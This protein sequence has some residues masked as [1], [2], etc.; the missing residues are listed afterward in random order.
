MGGSELDVLLKVLKKK[1][2]LFFN[3]AEKGPQ[4][5]FCLGA[6]P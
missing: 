3:F 5:E 1:E 4:G 6:D 2:L